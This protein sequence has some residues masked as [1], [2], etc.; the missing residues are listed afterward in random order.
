MNASMGLPQIAAFLTVAVTVDLDISEADLALAGLEQRISF[1]LFVK[2]YE[3]HEK[4]RRGMSVEC[5]KAIAA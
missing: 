5:H 3:V 2:N 1:I 4:W